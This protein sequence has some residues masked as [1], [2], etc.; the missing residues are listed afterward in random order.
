MSSD[1]VKKCA[2]H[3]P[4][5]HSL[6]HSLGDESS[7]MVLVAQLVAALAIALG[8]DTL[9]PGCYVDCVGS[10]TGCATGRLLPHTVAVHWNNMTHEVSKPGLTR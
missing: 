4:F 2:A 9:V 8:A 7:T 5:D 3:Y 1:A 10:K 6:T